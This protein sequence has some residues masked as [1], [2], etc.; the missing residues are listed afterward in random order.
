MEGALT[1]VA[2]ESGQLLVAVP[3]TARSSQ[4]M[5]YAFDRTDNGWTLHAG[6]VKTM[7]GR[8]GFAKPGE[9]REGDGH[10]PAGLFPLEFAF[11]YAPA[12]KTRMPYRQATE[13]DLW[14]DDDKSPDYN[15]W[16]RRGRS[17]ATSFEEMKRSDNLYRHGLVI[18]YNRM[19]VVAGLG[20]AIF[21]HVWREEGI[22]TAGCI[23]MAETDLVNLLVWLDPVKKPMILMGDPCDLKALPDLEGL[24]T[25]CGNESQ[26]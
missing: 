16:V 21:A 12:I 13:D 11:G 15:Q 20:S 9:K 5:L 3:L 24:A 7:V 18:G 1:D 2:P 4:G 8:N 23:A 26:R 22:A 6:P 17:S 10:N 19:P 14:V 25:L